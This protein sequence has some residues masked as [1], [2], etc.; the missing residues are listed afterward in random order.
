MV[1]ACAGVLREG[2]VF[3]RAELRSVPLSG[4][5]GLTLAARGAVSACG[6]VAGREAGLRVLVVRASGAGLRAGWVGA[7]LARAN[8]AGRDFGRAEAATAGRV[9]AGAG[10]ACGAGADA[11]GADAVG[12]VPAGAGASRSTSLAAEATAAG[13][14]GAVEAGGLTAGA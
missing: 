11:V 14:T 4:A 6:R 8:P 5:P 13:A 12:A 2:A 10:L 3:G 9:A 7:A 1:E